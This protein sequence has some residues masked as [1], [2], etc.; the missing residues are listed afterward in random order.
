MTPQHLFG[1]VRDDVVVAVVAAAARGQTQRPA[2]DV[3]EGLDAARCVDGEDEEIV[4][5]V[6]G[7]ARS[8]SYGRSYSPTPAI[9]MAAVA[10]GVVKATSSTPSATSIGFWRAAWSRRRGRQGDARVRQQW[11]PEADQRLRQ[12]AGDVPPRVLHVL[13]AESQRS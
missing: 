8:P 13:D 2:G 1:C 5:R 7:D 4:V 3:V 9:A 10:D 12:P 6:C 11:S